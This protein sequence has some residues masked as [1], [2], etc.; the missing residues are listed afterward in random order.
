MGKDIRDDKEHVRIDHDSARGRIKRN[1][2]NFTRGGQLFDS[3]IRQLIAVIKTP[4]ICWAIVIGIL[5]ATFLF[6]GIKE[7]QFQLI[8]MRLGSNFWM[9]LELDPAKE[10]VLK[11][12]SG[13]SVKGPIAMVPYHSAVE[14]AWSRFW[15]ITYV[16]LFSGFFICAPV[17]LWYVDFARKRGADIMEE[18]H[19]R[20]AIKVSFET[21]HEAIT[22]H[23]W[24]EH[25]A[26]CKRHPDDKDPWKEAD[27]PIID[28]VREGMHVPYN[29]AGLPYP[30]RLEQNH[31]MFVGTTGA[32]KTTALKKIV[33]QARTCGHRCVIFDL[34]GSFVES[35][36]D[37]TRDKIL[38]PM[39][40]RCQP[41]SVFND[42]ETYSDFMSAAV[43]LIPNTKSSDDN[44]W[45][46]A[47]RTL[48]IEMCLKM[49]AMGVHSNGAL[50]YFLMLC[51]LKEIHQYLSGTIAQSMMSPEVA[52]SAESIR[53][54][55]KAQAGILQ[56]LPEPTKDD[57]PFSIRQWMSEDVEE[58]SILFITSSYPD[59]ESN[60]P[61]LTLWLDLAVN[62]LLRMPRTRDLRT[63]FL[64]DEIHALH[65]V[66]A[67]AHGLQTSRG[68]GG[69]F[70]LGMHSFDALE[71]TYG[72]N[73]AT[74][75]ASLAGTK[76]ILKTADPETARRCSEF[77]GNREVRRP[78]EAYSYGYNSSRDASTITP[79]TQI[80]DLVIPIDLSLMQSLHGFVRFPDGFP[81]TRIK[82]TY[83]DY[84]QVAPGFDR[85]L[86][87]RATRFRP[88]EKQIA[89]MR[90]V[91]RPDGGSDIE[92]QI[93][94][95]RAENEHT[96]AE[97]DAAQ[98][99]EQI[100]ASIP[101][102]QLG[103]E[104]ELKAEGAQELSEAEVRPQDR[105][106]Q[107]F[108]RPKSERKKD[109][110]AETLQIEEQ[111]RSASAKPASRSRQ[112]DTSQD[113]GES[114]LSRENARG[115]DIGEEGS[116]PPTRFDDQEPE[117]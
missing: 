83:Q 105:Q 91:W 68:Y 23:N 104:E 64:I 48:F 76:L 41:W 77:I 19:E 45:V 22:K 29:L 25:V 43:A 69:A 51:D 99:R 103:A 55:F 18:R 15:T 60:K 63:W 32:G 81:A 56:Y 101:S 37:P 57:E 100:E 72:E 58:G 7:N 110:S 27:R 20:G 89:E 16:S 54:T 74:N 46:N 5:F 1:A 31:A 93:E 78:D 66:P 49:R 90:G 112:P 75:L 88:S 87:E 17:T 21:L 108:N 33:T 65:K 2:G 102:M 71:E 97:Q 80:E 114:E 82:L 44:F 113:K 84:E 96:I 9:W 26:E 36:Y 117:R 34:T 35:F 13:A 11:L 95:D 70:V 107:M 116:E 109:R 3:Q 38:N 92:Q 98:L 40:R 67:I 52:K 10:V 14:A 59:L 50:A 86:Q 53:S 4:L 94:A 62:A 30:W 47:A 12:P 24:K 6:L 106:L 111:G 61:L 39:D 115:F 42:C 28:R 85:V 79:R 73:G 8:M